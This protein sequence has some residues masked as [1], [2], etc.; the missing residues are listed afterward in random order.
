MLGLI[1]PIIRFFSPP[2]M[3][4]A[5]PIEI[6][7]SQ[8][9]EDRPTPVMYAGSPAYVFRKG[10]DIQ[11]LSLVCTHLQCIVIWDEPTQQFHC[12]CHDAQFGPDGRVLSG[13]P[14]RPLDAIKITRKNQLVI[15]GGE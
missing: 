14:E 11:V 10:D 12:P 5:K 7:L 3:V 15:I 8:L 9:S 13:P 1:Y 6:P 2:K 4:E